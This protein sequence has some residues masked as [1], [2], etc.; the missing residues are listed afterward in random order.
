MSGQFSYPEIRPTHLWMR[1]LLNYPNM[2]TP[3]PPPPDITGLIPVSVSLD[4]V[5]V[6]DHMC[7]HNKAIVKD[8]KAVITKHCYKTLH[9]LLLPTISSV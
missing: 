9:M 7:E 3:P 4:I 1:K 5:R 6:H 2:L 8:L